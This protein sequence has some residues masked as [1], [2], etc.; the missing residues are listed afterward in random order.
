MAKVVQEEPLVGMYDD[1]GRFIRV[2][3]AE[4]VKRCY[5]VGLGFAEPKRMI[6]PAVKQA[7]LQHKYKLLYTEKNGT[8]WY[9]VVKE[10]T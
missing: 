2:T 7:L 1:A 6:T 8:E 4:S 5:P 3:G 10:S 9:D